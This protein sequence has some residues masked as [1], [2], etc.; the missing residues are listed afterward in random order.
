MGWFSRRNGCYSPAKWIKISRK[1]WD[2]DE[3]S[4]LIEEMDLEID[5]DWS[6]TL[7]FSDVENFTPSTSSASCSLLA[8]VVSCQH[9]AGMLVSTTTGRR[10]MPWKSDAVS[11][12]RLC[13]SSQWRSDFSRNPRMSHNVC[14]HTFFIPNPD[15]H[16]GIIED[17]NGHTFFHGKLQ[18]PVSEHNSYII[19]RYNYCFFIFCN[20]IL[21]YGRM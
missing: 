4:N 19:Y 18:N 20:H 9:W 13:C 6:I 10:R 11:P 1:C 5:G 21:Q 2:N 15:L 12:P 3:T 7:G 16:T 14:I 8:V 17:G